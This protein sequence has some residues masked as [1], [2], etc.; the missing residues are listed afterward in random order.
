M[1]TES[2]DNVRKA[3][4]ARENPS[5]GRRQAFDYRRW[6]IVSATCLTLLF[7]VVAGVDWYL[8]GHADAILKRRMIETLQAR[9]SCPVEL[10]RLHLS[11]RHGIQVTGN[12]LRIENLNGPN[13]A[14][15]RRNTQPTVL[16]V[17]SFRFAFNLHALLRPTIRLVTIEADG[18]ELDIPPRGER[19]W[20]KGKPG[21]PAQPPGARFI[22]RV[23]FT[24][25]TIVV[26]TA[27]P[28]KLPLVFRIARLTLEDHGVRQ[29]LDYQVVLTNPKPLGEVRAVGHFGPWLR[30]NPPQVALDGHY[31]FLHA[32]LGTL[33][34]MGGTLSSTGDFKG[35]L[36]SVHVVGKTDSP[37]LTLTVSN[38]P[39]PVHSSFVATVNGTNGDTYLQNVEAQ[40]PHTRLHATGSVLRVE[41]S[42]ADGSHSGV[43]GHAVD[44]TVVAGPED[45]GR[46]EELLV[47]GERK[48]PPFMRGAMTMQMHIHVPPGHASLKTNVQVEGWLKIHGATFENPKF[49]Q[50]VDNLSGRA[51]KL[52][53][54]KRD[55]PIALTEIEG[56]YDLA[57]GVLRVP[58]VSFALPGATAALEGRYLVEQRTVDFTGIVR[59]DASASGMTTGWKSALLTPFDPLFKKNGAGM[60]IPVTVSGPRSAMKFKVDLKRLLR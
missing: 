34:G 51:A 5:R 9:F 27:Q 11:V 18:A 13:V 46:I 55:E 60:Q 59:T 2:A 28:G 19:G 36:G 42:G 1:P 4:G 58:A 20:K 24:R 16:T 17:A 40:M 31:S 52:K 22:T 44:L 56:R 10:D 47:L 48:T 41:P 30:G 54:P 3:G 21:G 38:H 33:R 43:R 14:L 37:D 23:V 50:T 35:Q 57:G 7:L 45:H 39:M 49:Q 8:R 12:G 53:D 6:L 26:Q 32:D 25:S 15:A 29:P